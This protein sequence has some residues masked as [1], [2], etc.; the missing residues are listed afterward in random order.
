LLLLASAVAATAQTADYSVEARFAERPIDR[1]LARVDPELDEW[2]GE[3]DYEAV[4]AKLKA[5]AKGVISGK[6]G[7]PPLAHELERF[8][9]LELVELKIVSSGRSSQTVDSA[10]IGVR[11]ELGGTAPDGRRLSLL[12]PMQMTWK[13]AGGDWAL[14]E[15]A[16]GTLR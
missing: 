2:I 3:R 14:A 15:A 7:F 13:R 8:A 1:V 10:E 16:V 9:K 4:N 5:I 12:G 6:E 11:V